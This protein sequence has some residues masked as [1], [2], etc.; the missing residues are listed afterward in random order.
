M[1]LPSLWGKRCEESGALEYTLPPFYALR[2][3]P[4]STEATGF[5]FW[6]LLP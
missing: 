2:A 6:E 3:T 1:Q 5:A 4:L